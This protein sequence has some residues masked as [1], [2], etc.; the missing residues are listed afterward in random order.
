MEATQTPEGVRISGVKRPCSLARSMDLLWSD[1]IGRPG[2]T[3]REHALDLI[4][5]HNA[6]TFS[7]LTLYTPAGELARW[8]AVAEVTPA[9]AAVQKCR[10]SGATSSGRSRSGGIRMRS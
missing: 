5:E 4:V 3:V 6:D 1:T 10:T 7:L 2:I 8:E 9:L